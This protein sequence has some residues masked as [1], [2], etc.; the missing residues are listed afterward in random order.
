M[1]NK[2]TE[3]Y[4]LKQ[5]MTSYEA[6]K[7]EGES[8]IFCDW[9]YGFHSLALVLYQTWHMSGYKKHFDKKE[10]MERAQWVILGTNHFKEC[11][12]PA[13]KGIRFDRLIESPES[14]LNSTT[15]KH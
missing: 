13:R 2:H 8:W 1:I 9:V 5:M 3:R 4:S 11:I 6:I 10:R 7:N 12:F 15:A 14:K